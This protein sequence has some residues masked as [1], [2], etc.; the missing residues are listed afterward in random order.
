MHNKEREDQ[1]NED[2]TKEEREKAFSDFDSDF[3]FE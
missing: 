1:E 2:L 3:D